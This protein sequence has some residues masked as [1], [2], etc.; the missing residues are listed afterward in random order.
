[1]GQALS[2][3]SSAMS[4]VLSS[5]IL[6]DAVVEQGAPSL[7]GWPE[8]MR[9]RDL[10]RQ[11]VRYRAEK[12]VLGGRVRLFGVHKGCIEYVKVS[13]DLYRRVDGPCDSQRVPA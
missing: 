5:D 3:M 10:R 8:F 4:S 9:T 1:M 7:A 11:L 12:S 13:K 2:V 6:S